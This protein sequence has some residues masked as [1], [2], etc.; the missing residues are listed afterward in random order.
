[1]LLKY[2]KENARRNKFTPNLIFEI[3]PNILNKMIINI[4]NGK[5]NSSLSQASIKML[6]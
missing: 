6:F 4:L 5:K 2:G 1:M 3:I